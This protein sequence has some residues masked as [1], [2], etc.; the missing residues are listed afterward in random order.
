M[1]TKLN[2]SYALFFFSSL[3]LFG[4]LGTMAPSYMVTGPSHAPK[5]SSDFPL[6]PDITQLLLTQDSVWDCPLQKKLSDYS[7]KELVIHVLQRGYNDTQKYLPQLASMDFGKHW[8]TI[9]GQFAGLNILERLMWGLIRLWGYVIWVVSSST[10]SFLMNNLSLAIIVASLMA[11]SVLMARAAQL[12]FKILQLCLPV[13]AARMVM[14]AFTTMKRVCIERPKSYV[15]ECAVR[16]FTTWAVPMKP[17][18]NSILLISHDDGSHAGYATCVTLHDR[19]ST[20]IG[21]ITCSHAPING[22]V[23]STVTGNKIKM[24]SFKTLYDDAETDVKILFGPPNWESVMGCKALKLVTRDSLAK[25]PATI[26]TFG[27]NGWT[28]SQASISGAYDKNKASVL[29]ITDKGHSGAP[30]ISGKNVIGIHSGGDVVDNVNVCSTIPKIVNLTTPQLV[31]E[32]TAP[33]GRLFLEKEM[34]DLLEYDWSC[35]EARAI[36]KERFE[37]GLYEGKGVKSY[38]FETTSD[39]VS[40]PIVPPHL[41]GNWT[42]RRRPPNNRHLRKHPKSNARLWRFLKARSCCDSAKFH[43]HN[44]S[45]WNTDDTRPRCFC[46]DPSHTKCTFGSKHRSGIDGSSIE[47]NKPREYRRESGWTD[48]EKRREAIKTQAKDFEKFF[49]GQYRWGMGPTTQEVCGFE[50]V[51]SLPKFYHSKQRLNSEYGVRV[52]EEHSELKELTAGFGWPKFGAQAELTSLRL[53]ADRWLQR[54]ESAQIPSQKAR[55][56]VINRLVEA[57]SCARTN[58]PTSTAGNSLTWEGFIEDIKEAVSSLELDAGVGV[59]YIAYGTR[60]HR[61][62]VFNQELLPVLTRLTFNRLQKMLEVNSDDL[63]AEQLVQHGLCDP[64][65]VF[66]KGEPHKVSKLE[67]GRYRLIMSV[68]LV[69]QLVARVLFQNQNKR[70]IEL[71]R[72]VPSKP[73]FGLSTDDQIED[74]VKVLASQL[75]EEPQEVFNNW[76]TK[77]IPTDCSGFDWSVADWMLEDDMEVRNRLTRNNNHTTKRL[78]SVWLK[79]ISNSVLCLS[80][81]RLLSQRVPGVQKSGSYNTSSSNSRIRVMAAY[82]CGASWAMAMGDDALESVDSNLTEYKKLGFKVEVAKQLEFCSHIFKNERLALPLNVKKML[83]KLIYGYNPDSGNLEAIKNYLDACHS[84]VNEIRHDESLVQKIISW[85][86]IPVQPQN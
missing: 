22:S 35:Q 47:P 42:E 81:G 17:P 44:A 82:H 45:G 71:W 77:L 65:R 69:D 75:G 53:Q 49:E 73:G 14:S 63:N 24:E 32:T 79:C 34:D 62:W 33:Q 2:S 5:I 57:Y 39:N 83:Y 48:S 25:G 23:F 16:G 86:V 13:L 30:Y 68:S 72:A 46:D 40:Y 8:D 6:P 15:K 59:P 38:D 60:T 74:F 67:E 78:R 18:K 28:S 80:D 56:S 26:Y 36:I 11:L 29:S 4:A 85:L 51:G 31:F 84:I 52:A 76:S 54:M 12:F 64:I 19:Q 70:E 27:D 50:E 37:R 9:S 58:A 61:D 1:D 7:Y 10:M 41:P 43:T 3:I 21:L 20:T 66:V 55:E